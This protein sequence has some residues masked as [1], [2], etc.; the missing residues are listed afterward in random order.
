MGYVYYYAHIK[1]KMQAGGMSSR[2]HYK[3][4]VSE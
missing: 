3:R 2:L 4:A 1:P